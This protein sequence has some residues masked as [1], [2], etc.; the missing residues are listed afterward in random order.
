MRRFVAFACL[1]SL[2]NLSFAGGEWSCP[3]H[4][5]DSAAQS[6]QNESSARHHGQDE[7]TDD[8]TPTDRG[9]KSNCCQA[10]TVCSGAAVLPPSGSTL[11]ADVPAT[12]RLI[13]ASSL[14]VSRVESPDPPPPKA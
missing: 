12:T 8:R 4:D 1:F 2:A 13:L 11:I 14:F 5:A 10:M 6:T 7:R 9:P 3:R